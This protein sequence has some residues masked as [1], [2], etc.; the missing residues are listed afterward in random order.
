MPSLCVCKLHEECLSVCGHCCTCF[1]A[2]F[3]PGMKHT[4]A[5]HSLLS[6]LAN[7]QQKWKVIRAWLEPLQ[8]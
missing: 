8:T 3:S 1:L 5:M 7:M 4:K 2:P 6:I